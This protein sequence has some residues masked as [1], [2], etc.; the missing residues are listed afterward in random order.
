MEF[1]ENTPKGVQLKGM[2][3]DALNAKGLK[4]Q[5]IIWR[6]GEAVKLLAPKEPKILTITGILNTP[7]KWLEK[8]VNSTIIEGV[9]LQ[10]SEHGSVPF[11]YCHIVVDRDKLNIVL[12]ISE[13]DHY[14]AKIT[15]K[16]ELHPSFIKFGINSGTYRTPFEMAD[17]IKMNRSFFENT[18][19]AMNLVTELKN[20]KG[21]VNK[22]LEASDNNRGDKKVVIDQV[23]QT[24]IPDT[25]KINVPIFKGEKKSTLSVEVYINSEDLTCTLVSPEANDIVERLRDTAIDEVLKNIEAIA[26]KITVIEQ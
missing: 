22:A 6:E 2:L 12:H 4:S 18:T 8:R 1:E 11:Q 10:S 9:V 5:E 21:K 7:E 23:V 14:G 16:M 15:G 20:F 3:E 13:Q 19:V 25:F 26:P 17:L 24:N